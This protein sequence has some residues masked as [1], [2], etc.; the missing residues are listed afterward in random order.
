[1]A[2]PTIA[3]TSTID[4]VHRGRW[5]GSRGLIYWCWIVNDPTFITWC[6]ADEDSR[7][8]PA[9]PLCEWQDRDVR[10]LY[11]P[12]GIRIEW[13]FSDG[14]MSCHSFRCEVRKQTVVCD[15]REARDIYTVN[16]D[17]QTL[18]QKESSDG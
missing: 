7:T 11:D 16:A 4:V 10:M 5:A 14:F 6:L 1:M 13:Q 18:P 17:G 8:F 3:V 12:D 9:C 15:P 2:D